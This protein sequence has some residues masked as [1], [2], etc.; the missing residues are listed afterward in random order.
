MARKHGFV[1]SPM[2]RT[3]SLKTLAREYQDLS[4]QI[5]A[6]QR[7][8]NLVRGQLQAQVGI[9]YST[10][11]KLEPGAFAKINVIKSTREDYDGAKL[12]EYVTPSVLAKCRKRVP[13]VRV[14]VAPCTEDVYN[15][16]FEV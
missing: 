5:A 3:K 9:D 6:L 11:V 7:K 4:E 16:Y 14:T 2:I 13:Y 12:L 15:S 8:Q 1:P 10:V